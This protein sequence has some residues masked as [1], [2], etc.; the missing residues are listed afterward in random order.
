M[1][2]GDE[3]AAKQC[4]NKFN[5]L[6]KYDNFVLKKGKI[7]KTN[8]QSERDD[9]DE[10]DSEEDAFSYDGG[11]SSLYE[12]TDLE[13]FILKKILLEH[14][15]R[16]DGGFFAKELSFNNNSLEEICGTI[17]KLIEDKILYLSANTR[18]ER[19]ENEEGI[20]DKSGFINWKMVKKLDKNPQE[21]NKENGCVIFDI[22]LVDEVKLK[23]RIDIGIEEF[24]NDKVCTPLGMMMDK[25]EID[26][27]L[28]TIEKETDK[29]KKIADEKTW[30]PKRIFYSYYKQRTIIINEIGKDNKRELM[31]PL[32]NFGDRQVDVL[33]TLLALEKE[34]LLRITELISNPPYDE[35][36]NFI[37]NWSAKD[38]PVARIY[39]LKAQENKQEPMVLKIIEMPELKIKGFEEKVVLQKPKNK[40]IQLRKLPENTKWNNITVRFLNGHEVIIKAQNLT[41]QTN[42]EEMG[43]QDE[44]KKL[45]NKQWQFLKLLALKNGEI[46]WENNQ[47]LPLQQ[48][49]SI[50][51]QK[52]LLVE[53]LKAYF[54]INESPFYDYKKENAYK[55]RINL[56]PEAGV[57]NQQQDNLGI[58]EEYKKQTPSVYDEHEDK[59]NL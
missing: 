11:I 17:N 22:D 32:N 45:P 27:I 41:Y 1:H 3:E 28:A 46:S 9:E 23:G 6:L 37:D 25:T 42:Y 54:Q 29:N 51:K 26:Q 5:N 43:F 14:K 16:D 53:A 12:N 2:N 48:I 8:Q 59:L 49:N 40:R 15:R 56:I 10:E 38:N 35:K 31:I 52:Q 24:M 55:I 13:L 47:D 30:K 44:K 4:K 50:K 18:P 36:G 19:F 39:T 21:M 58:Q 57:Q 33:K 20:E 34:N 7:E